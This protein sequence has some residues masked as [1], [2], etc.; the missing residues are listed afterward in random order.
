F[1][2]GRGHVILSGEAYT[3][4]DIHNNPRPWAAQHYFT[5]VD[6]TATSA[7]T[8]K[9]GPEYISARNTVP[10]QLAPGGI[11]TAVAGVPNSPAIGTYF[12]TNAAVGN[13]AYGQV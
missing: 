6:S 3:S 8:A 11:I 2:G 10:S 5:V 7:A 1:D 4:Q 12:G 9:G 13:L